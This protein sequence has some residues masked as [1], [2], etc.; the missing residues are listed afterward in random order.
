MSRNNRMMNKNRIAYRIIEVGDGG[1][2]SGWAAEFKAPVWKGWQRLLWGF[3]TEAGVKKAA[4]A[5]LKLMKQ[6]HP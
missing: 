3:D 6:E 1:G 4:E 5:K 2:Q